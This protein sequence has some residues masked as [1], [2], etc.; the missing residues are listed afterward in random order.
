V[1]ACGPGCTVVADGVFSDAAGA[2]PAALSHCKSHG[3][4]FVHP[5][6]DP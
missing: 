2:F 4:T 3:Y 5:F 6:D 1:D